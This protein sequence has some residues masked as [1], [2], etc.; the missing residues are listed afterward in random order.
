M[1]KTRI[2][3]EICPSDVP[4]IQA[5]TW[6]GVAYDNYIVNYGTWLSDNGGRPG[7]GDLSW[8]D[9]HGRLHSLRGR[10]DARP[11]RLSDITDGTSNTLL[12]AEILQGQYNAAT[13][14][15]DVRGITWWG[16]GTGFMTYLRPNDTNPDVMWGSGW[17]NPLPPNAPCTSADPNTTRT[18]AARSRHA[19][20]VN[21]CF[22]DGELPLH[23][24][25]H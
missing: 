5:H 4:A 9:L 15:S 10:H 21:V 19:G 20:G 16:S 8:C 6:S 25:R 17:C 23:W 18:F 12:M 22:G 24:Q 1:T 3:S 13:G 14:N 2:A 11:Q 7:H